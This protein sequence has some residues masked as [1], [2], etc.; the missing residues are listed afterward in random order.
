MIIWMKEEKM[1]KENKIVM[2]CD[3]DTDEILKLYKSQIGRK[4]C[5]WDEHYPGMKEIEFDLSRDSLF[6]M[7]DKN[8]RIIAAISIDMD[9][10]VESLECW[11]ENLQP[12][13]ELARLAVLGEWQNHGIA[14]QMI[15]YA[16][17]IL[18]QRGRRS[19]HFLVNKKNEKAL[20]SYAHLDFNVVGECE[21]YEQPFLCYEKGLF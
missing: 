16:M 12:G 18:A 10:N 20:R 5:P 11:S 13:G 14:R 6:V 19:V 1:M 8:N 17:N 4:F 21:L 9:E 3:D 2:A 15:K 7:K